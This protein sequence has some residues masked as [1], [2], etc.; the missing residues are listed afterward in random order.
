MQQKTILLTGASS[1][2]GRLT[3]PLLLQRGHRVIAGVRGGDDRLRE[4]F[5]A[6]DAD[7]GR[8]KAI[9]L[10][11]DRPE[12]FPRVRQFIEDKYEGRLDVLI[13]NAGY[14]LVGPAEDAPEETA[15]HQLEVNFFGP[16]LLTQELLPTLRA[17]KGR[18]LNVSSVSGFV[19]YPFYALYAASKHALEGYTEALW[20]EVEPFG[21]QVGL[22]EPGGSRT[23]FIKTSS[24]A[25]ADIPS[26]SLYADRSRRMNEFLLGSADKFAGDPKA[27]A[28]VLARLCDRRRVPLRTLVGFD[29]RA[30]EL[31]RR[32]LPHH[33]RAWLVYFGFRKLVFKD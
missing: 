18:I 19:P 11:L 3:V 13:N 17:A 31:L 20:S 9:D 1:G 6:E 25:T 22:I 5:G 14:G 27:V 8:L 26:G 32:L 2:F 7:A 29:S 33:L 10:H 15:R 16:I 28:K 30:L 4:I 12:S 23:G 24:K 21:I